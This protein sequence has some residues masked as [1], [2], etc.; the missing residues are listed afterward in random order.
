MGWNSLFCSQLLGNAADAPGFGGFGVVF[1]GS[2]GFLH[3]QLPDA[4]RDDRSPRAWQDL[5]V[6]EAHPLPQLDRG[7]HQRCVRGPPARPGAGMALPF[8]ES[9]VR[10]VCRKPSVSRAR[11]LCVKCSI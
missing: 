2:M 1:F 10:S 3:D 7:A 6:Q 4:D 9:A 8:A 5:R 11:L